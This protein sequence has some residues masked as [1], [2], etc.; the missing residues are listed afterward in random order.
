MAIAIAALRGAY[1]APRPDSK[2]SRFLFKHCRKLFKAFVKEL[3]VILIER[4]FGG[5]GFNMAQAIT[6]AI[7]AIHEPLHEIGRIFA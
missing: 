7:A 4:S 6:P 1:R 3:L 2:R 5:I